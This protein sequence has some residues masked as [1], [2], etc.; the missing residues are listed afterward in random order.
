[1]KTPK[2]ECKNTSIQDD[3]KAY[4]DN[5]LP[6]V[7]RWFVS[8]HLSRC[9]HCRQE[10][11]EMENITNNVKASSDE[12]A[13]SST[14]KDKIL[15]SAPATPP[16]PIEPMS[17]AA[18]PRF[19]FAPYG[20]QLAAVACVLV[21]FVGA[22]MLT[23]GK[24]VQTVFNAANTALNTSTGYEDSYSYSP[25]AA[26]PDAEPLTPSE[27]QRQMDTAS[28]GQQL[29]QLATQR[30]NYQSKTRIAGGA[31]TESLPSSL[32][33]VHK[34]AR[35][36]VEVKQIEDATNE[37]IALVKSVGGYIA[38][39][40]LSTGADNTKTAT[41]E[42]RIPVGNFET[43]LGQVGKQGEV[44]AKHVVG[45]DV[46]QQY[47]DAQQETNVITSELGVREAQLS[48]AL[49]RAEQKK[50]P[51]QVPWQQRAEVRELRVRSAQ[52]RARL[53]LLKK[54]SDLGN[55]SIELQEK[56]KVPG[57]GGFVD[58]VSV[59]GQEAMQTFL[60]A[61]RVPVNCIMWVLAYSPL[62]LPLL[63]GARF[64]FGKAQ[65]SA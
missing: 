42:A 18:Q 34:E 39:N 21:L 30:G 36:T 3:L 16:A 47:S 5:E 9:A 28:S 63:I 20:R 60:V 12:P 29:D 6:A 32:R 37:T 43:V 1:M 57:E 15:S 55:I 22:S 19:N 44:R 13:L 10:M 56:V 2:N 58:N 65:R 27:I 50:K 38:N 51:G 11:V 25:P 59:T 40:T 46:T 35:I 52:A 31:N 49:K 24:K 41:I 64:L 33:K 45:E 54:I 61:A 62:W 53:A 4:I 23:T 26:S 14:L 8:L 7:R 48:D 17:P